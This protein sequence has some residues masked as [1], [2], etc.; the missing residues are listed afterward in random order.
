MT[1]SRYEIPLPRNDI[2]TRPPSNDPVSTTS[3]VD[4]SL[5][6]VTVED[7]LTDPSNILLIIISF[8]ALLWNVLS[9]AAISNIPRNIPRRD[10]AH[11]KI[12]LSL[13][14]AD[15][16]IIISVFTHL[17][18]KIASALDMNNDCVVLLE[19]GVLDLGIL[20]SLLNLLV[21]GIDR[22]L[23][24]MKPLR[25]LCLMSKE[26]TKII[27]TILWA[28][29]PLGL[30]LEIIIG[31]ILDS[32]SGSQFSTGFEN[33]A[34]N[35]SSNISLNVAETGAFNFCTQ[36]LSD[37]FDARIHCIF[38]L[39]VLAMI[40]LLYM[41]ARIYCTV[42][43]RPTRQLRHESSRNILHRE[44]SNASSRRTKNNNK[45][46]ISSA[47][48]VGT[49]MLCW[50]PNGIFQIAIGILINVDRESVMKNVETLLSMHEIFWILMVFSTL[51]HPIIYACRLHHVRLGYK[52]L[53]HKL[54]KCPVKETWK[55]KETQPPVARIDD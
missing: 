46:I 40:A 37:K 42:R 50:V 4:S 25:H 51:C 33:F 19:K 44:S 30:L 35:N 36:I 3:D 26:R 7:I 54:L 16:V 34:G 10:K 55:K 53:F 47:L 14:I 2:T 18:Q 13:S 1:E 45:T 32:V 27:I 38:G 11:Y 52:Y 12:A 23:A 17:I 21:M 15:I 39:V 31:A 28:I 24:I 49:F 9:V 43:R 22:Y 6:E 48:I 41:Y 20:A 29:C 8:V 5:E